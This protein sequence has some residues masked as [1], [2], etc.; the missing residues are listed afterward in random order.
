MSLR[1]QTDIEC[2]CRGCFGWLDVVVTRRRA[3]SAK[4][5]RAKAAKRGWV[6]R[7]GRDLCPTCAKKEAS[8]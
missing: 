4:K 2:D 3:L 7:R 8:E 1:I 6:V 5:V